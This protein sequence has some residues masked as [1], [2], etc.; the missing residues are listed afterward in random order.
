MLEK[1]K[2]QVCRANLDLVKHGLVLFTWGNVSAIDRESGL[3]VIKPSGVSYDTMKPEDMVVVDLAGKVVEGSLKPS[4][5]TP[6]HLVLYKAFP[7]IGGIVHTHSTFATAWAQAGLDIPCIGTTHADY[8]LGSIPCTRSMKKA[9]V[10]GEYETETGNVIVE[11]FKGMDPIDTPAVLVRNHGPFTWGTDP[12]NAVHNAVVL[13]E[14]AK[15][16][17]AS[18]TIHLSTLDIVNHKP[19]MN[20][21]LIEKH[22]SRKHGPDAYYGQKKK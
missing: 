13:E 17:F 22:Y 19:T 20:R 9:E 21:H 18:C 7:E 16:A 14:V 4:S 10:Q 15:M 6:T 12:D 1:L 11:R 8:F 3:V 5:D 2:E